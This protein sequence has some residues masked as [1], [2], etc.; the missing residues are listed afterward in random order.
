MEASNAVTGRAETSIRGYRPPTV[1]LYG[2]V[3]A[4]TLALTVGSIADSM[5]MLMVM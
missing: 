3:A 4:R 5:A 2:S 1:V